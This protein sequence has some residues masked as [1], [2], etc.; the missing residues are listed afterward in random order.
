MRLKEFIKGRWFPLVGT[1]LILLVV[2]IGMALF[3]WRITYAPELEN[4]WEAISAIATWLGVL[5]SFIAIMV[6]IQIPKIIAER[7][8][9]IVLFEKRFRIYSLILLCQSFALALKAAGSIQDAWKIF[10]LAFYPDIWD[11]EK[12]NDTSYIAVCYH[13]II[14]ELSLCDFLFN[15]EISTRTLLIVQK[16]SCLLHDWFQVE[17]QHAFI[18][19]KN[20]YIALYDDM[21]L[22]ITQMKP[23]LNLRN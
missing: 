7:Q 15:A 16:M 11:N 6:A 9:K 3:G 22:L 4:S 20:E 5:A 1:I 18:K 13:K 23:Y 14:Q 12:F 17:D 2:G 19:H 10:L 21:N 8:D